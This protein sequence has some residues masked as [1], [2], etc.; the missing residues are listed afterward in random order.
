MK[1]TRTHCLG[2]LCFAVLVPFTAAC[3]ESPT[4]PSLSAAALASD[5]STS[6]VAAQGVT[7]NADNTATPSSM[8]VLAGYKVTFYNR[9]GRMLVLQSTDCWEFNYMSLAVGMSRN[10]SPFSPAGKTCHYWVNASSGK[11]FVGQI[12]VQ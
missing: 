6:L 4:A 11:T 10:T 1:M 9:S 3:G 8:A 12:T 5:D 2:V 7:L